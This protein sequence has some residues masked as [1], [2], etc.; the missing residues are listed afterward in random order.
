MSLPRLA[1]ISKLA[2]FI[3]VPLAIT[4]VG[5]CYAPSPA[6]AACL[7]LGIVAWTFLEYWMHRALHGPQ[8]LEFHMQHHRRPRDLSGGALYSTMIIQ[9]MVLVSCTWPTAAPAL[10][11]VLIGYLWFICVHW[12][13]HHTKPS[14]IVMRR[15]ASN[16]A[17]HHR[18]GQ[19]M[20]GVST[21]LW[22]HVF[23]TTE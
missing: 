14:G 21:A 18:G 12:L 8:L 4:A 16:H 6:A 5:F 23:G 3:T 19:R 10:Q 2:D 11:G 20:Y 9:F 7:I 13:I 15:F 17:A 1:T 22:D